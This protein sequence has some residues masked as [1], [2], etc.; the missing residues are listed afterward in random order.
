MGK[1]IQLTETE[2]INLIER[3]TKRVINE[4]EKPKKLFIPRK[5]EGEGSRWGQW[6]KEQPIANGIQ[7]NQYDI[8]GKP[9][10]YWDNW[11]D[12]DTDEPTTGKGFFIKGLKNGMWEE[13]SNVSELIGKGI[14]KNGEKEGVWESYWKNGNLA[15]KGSYKNG[16]KEGVW[17]QYLI[18]GQLLN[19]GSYINDKKDDIWKF[20]FKDSGE[21]RIRRLYKDDVKVRE[22][23]FDRNS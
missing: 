22:V 7:I 5:L 17:E 19:K 3:M 14:Y 9:I 23:I 11:N 6:N 13:Y 15:E 10:G 12:W 1:K 8:N 16:E 21:L 4:S 20:Y 2:L 18:N